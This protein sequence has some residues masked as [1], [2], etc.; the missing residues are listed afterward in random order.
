MVSK[1]H[2]TCQLYH[3]LLVQ[4]DTFINATLIFY[5]ASFYAPFF[6]SWGK[7]TELT[8]MIACVNLVQSILRQANF[9][10]A[11]LL[12]ASFFDADLTGLIL[13]SL[14]FFN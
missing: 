13:F 12:G 14:F 4:T 3:L 7:D 9:K 1:M 6:K 8:L 11:K 2:Q 5:F 10:G